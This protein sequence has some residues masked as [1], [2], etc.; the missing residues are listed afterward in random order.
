[1]GVLMSVVEFHENYIRCLKDYINS[2]L[3]DPDLNLDTL[4]RF[5][6]YSKFYSQKLFKRYMGV[7]IQKYIQALTLSRIAG[8]LVET[9]DSIYDLALKYNYDSQQ[10]LC[11][12]F[13]AYFKISPARYRRMMQK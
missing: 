9:D 12:R 11:R 2:N 10:S 6:G 5:G 4:T 1:V 7:T 13:T 8:E 3:E